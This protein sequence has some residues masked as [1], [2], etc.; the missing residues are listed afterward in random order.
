MTNANTPATAKTGGQLWVGC[1]VLAV[2]ALMA[3]GAAMIPAEA[4]YSGV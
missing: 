2:G 3:A 1:G 4:G